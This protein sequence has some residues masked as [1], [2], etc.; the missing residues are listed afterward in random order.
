M[1]GAVLLVGITAVLIFMI[2]SIMRVAFKKTNDSA[3][4][5]NRETMYDVPYTETQTTVTPAT[6]PKETPPAEE[7]QI[8]EAPAPI[9]EQRATQPMPEVPGQTEEQ[10]KAPEPV[11]ETA[12]Q[13]VDSPSAR[14]V[15][16]N[17]NNEAMFGSNLRHPEAMMTRAGPNFASLESEV[18]SGVAGRPE[19]EKL[20]FSAEMAQNGGEFMSGI[21]AFDSSDSG[22]TFSAY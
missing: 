1:Y 4:T 18:A 6:L 22:T 16:D 8:E 3:A 9:R 15:F 13:R 10:L 5:Q 17:T 19:V 21:F 11:Q 14:D 7:S 2:F 12:A 20:P